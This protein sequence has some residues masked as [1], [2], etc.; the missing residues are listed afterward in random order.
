M[1]LL[2][3]GL[4]VGKKMADC[5]ESLRLFHLSRH[6]FEEKLWIMVFICDFE[7]GARGSGPFLVGLSLVWLARLPVRYRNDLRVL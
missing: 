3:L 2:R 1:W 5:R 4:G 7:R 6:A